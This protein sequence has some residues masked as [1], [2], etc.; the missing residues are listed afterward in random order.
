MLRSRDK[1]IR[2]EEVEIFPGSPFIDR[3]IG[4]TGIHGIQGVTLLAIRDKRNEDYLFNP[5]GSR[6]LTADDVIIVIGGI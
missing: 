1:T 4:E 5:P 2:V 6:V 3:A